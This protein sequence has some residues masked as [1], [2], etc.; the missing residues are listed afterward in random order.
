M[1]RSSGSKAIRN[2]LGHF[3]V[4][5]SVATSQMVDP[6]TRLGKI[7]TWGMMTYVVIFSFESPIRYALNLA[8]VD[9][10]ILARDMLID[11]PFMLVSLLQLLEHK[12]SLALKVFLSLLVIEGVAFFLNFGVILPVI[13]G[14]KLLLNIAFG[15]VAGA[16]L[17]TPSR[18]VR[19]LLIGLFVVSAT[20][21]LL[22]KYVLRFPW[23]GMHAV[24]AGT[25]IELSKDWQ[26]EDSF[27]RR[28]GGFTHE[29]INAAGLLPVLALIVAQKCRWWILRL[30]VLMMGVFCVFLTTQ[31]GA[32][33]GIALVSVLLMLPTR[34]RL[35]GLRTTLTAG[36]IGEMLLPF[37]TNGMV[38]AQGGGSV[39][40]G[41]S[42]AARVMVTWPAATRWISDHSIFPFGVGI[43][44]MGVPLRTVAPG[45]WEFPDNM[46]LFV[47]AYF[48]VFSYAIYAIVVYVAWRSVRMRPEVSE[49]ALAV[50]TFL[51]FY[52][53]VI[54]VIEDQFM[55]LA[56]GSSLGTLFAAQIV[57]LASITSPVHTGA[58]GTRVY[59]PE[60]PPQS[61]I[62]TAMRG[63]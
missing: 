9:S 38:M 19:W 10:L 51:I 41:S 4:R 6:Q 57:P 45:V 1:S 36:V 44:G 23:V 46:F 30:A 26:V 43:G 22:E 32:I 5:R 13:F 42:F 56:L 8:H 18:R 31:K 53:M 28:V 12:V 61:G 48:G 14:T 63:F 21:I 11:I 37:V 25:E 27:S 33:V 49:P 40:S 39:F 2:P 3:D 55:A 7:C 35:L 47:W 52:G 15:L 58:G 17:I 34:L 54:S 29:S 24:I 20:G 50:A 60:P 16:I 62:A 59:G